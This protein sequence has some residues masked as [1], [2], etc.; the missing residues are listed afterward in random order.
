MDKLAAVG[1]HTEKWFLWQKLISFPKD[2]LKPLFLRINLCGA[3]RVFLVGCFER[4]YIYLIKISNCQVW[5]LLIFY[6][7]VLSCF[8]E[9]HFKLGLLKRDVINIEDLWFPCFSWIH[10]YF[11]FHRTILH[12]WNIRSHKTN[13]DQCISSQSIYLKRNLAL[14]SV[15]PWNGKWERNKPV[16]LSLNQECF[17]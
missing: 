5:F 10:T 14:E 2:F 9:S 7:A 3:W 13:R 11:G 17:E 12:L 4:K 15:L 8:S 1:F 6:L 16:R